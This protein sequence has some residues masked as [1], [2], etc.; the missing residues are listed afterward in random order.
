MTVKSRS[1]CRERPE[2]RRDGVIQPRVRRREV[3]AI[4][5]QAKEAEDGPTRARTV[6]RSTGGNRTGAADPVGAALMASS[7]GSAS[8]MPAPFKKVRRGSGSR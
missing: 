1:Q 2:D 3:P 6:R 7:Q 4:D 5:A 8:V